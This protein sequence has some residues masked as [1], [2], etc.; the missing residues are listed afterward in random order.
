MKSVVKRAGQERRVWLSSD[1]YTLTVDGSATTGDVSLTDG[2]IPPGG[3]P[4]PHIHRDATEIIYVHS[5]EI[6]VTIDDTEHDLQAGD[7][8]VIAPKTVHCFKNNTTTPTRL[9]LVFTPAGTEEF[10][11][12]AGTPAVPGEPIPIATPDDNRRAADIGLRHGMD[13]APAR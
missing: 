6:T 5:G 9:I 10:F 4:P 11:A 3:G 8:A 2:W 1:V 12:E 13:P 7:S